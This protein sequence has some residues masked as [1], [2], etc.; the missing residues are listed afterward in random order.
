[1]SKV[2]ALRGLRVGWLVC[3]DAATRARIETLSYNANSNLCAP[4]ELLGAIAL[5]HS[6]HLLERNARIARTNLE[7]VAAFVA[8]S[9]GL[10][11]WRR[12]TAGLVAWLTWHGPGSAH[13]LARWA[14][15]HEHVLVADQPPGEVGFAAIAE[16]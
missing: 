15:Q 1:M 11:S 7:E 16:S 3:R 2:Y 12:P 14:L 10:F 4:T 8:R 13:D 5:E 6:A 9:D